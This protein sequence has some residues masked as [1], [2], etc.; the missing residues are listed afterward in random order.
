MGNGR[1]DFVQ[2]LLTGAP[3]GSK[4]SPPR[5]P[6]RDWSTPPLESHVD[7]EVWGGASVSPI[8]RGAR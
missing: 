4:F 2:E 5:G 6:V 1:K 7:D 8:V 3:H